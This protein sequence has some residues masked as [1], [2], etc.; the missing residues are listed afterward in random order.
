MGN[1]FATTKDTG[2]APSGGAPAAA[3]NE[4]GVSPRPAE[5]GPRASRFAL[6]ALRKLAGFVAYAAGGVAVWEIIEVTVHPAPYILPTLPD[7][8]DY[9]VANRST[10]LSYAGTTLT[11]VVFGFAVGFGLAVFLAIVFDSLPIVRRVVWP[12]LLVLQTTPKVALAP[13]MLL[14]FGFGFVSKVALAALLSFFP[15]LIDTITGLSGATEQS[16]ELGRSMRMSGLQFYRY[17][18]LPG[19]LPHIFSGAKVGVTLATIGA[20]VGEFIAANSGLGYLIVIGQGR[21]NGP[22]IMAGILGLAVLGSALYVVV[23]LLERVCIRWH[24]SQRRQQRM[25]GPGRAGRLGQ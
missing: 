15:A 4:N 7:F 18:K 11:E 10:V 22:A 8:W 24:V 21:L 12:Y 23:D 2:I 13:W 5:A 1:V 20:I 25:R 19:A 16:E 9:L 14:I 3:D 17:V 6:L